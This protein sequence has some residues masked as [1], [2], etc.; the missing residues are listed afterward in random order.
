MLI[1][2]LGADEVRSICNVSAYGGSDEELAPEDSIIGQERAIRSLRLGLD[3]ASSG[4]N[5][6]VAGARGTGR[7]TA[8][9]RFLKSVAEDK[10]EPQDYCYVNNFKSPYEPKA[11][12]LPAG[13][14]HAFAS[15][16]SKLVESA[17]KEIPE[18][19]ESEDYNA[20]K[21][22]VVSSFNQQREQML[23]ELNE[24]ARKKGF[25]IQATAA[26]LFIVP[27]KDNQPMREQDLMKLDEEERQQI[28]EQQQELQEE[29][30]AVQ[31]KIQRLQV[32]A[33]QAVD[34]LDREVALY[35]VGE[36]FTDLE[37]KY[38]DHPKVVEYLEALKEDLLDNIELFRTKPEEQQQQQ[39]QMPAPMGAGGQSSEELFRKYEVNVLVDNSETKGAPVWEE[40]NPTH[41]NLFG[42][43]EKE[44]R[45]GA[46]ATDFTLIRAGA[47]HRANGGFLIVPAEDLLRNLFAWEGLK[48]ILQNQEIVIEEASERLGFMA[49]RS[50]NPE[51]IPLQLKVVIVGA[52]EIYH[53]LHMYDPDFKEL[54]KV[55][56]EFDTEMDCI[57][58]NVQ[59]YGSFFQT[60]CRKEDLPVLDESA[61]NRMVEYGSRLAANQ[62][63]LSTRFAD[64]ADIVRE[65]AHY[66]VEEG[67]D[68]ITDEHI[69]K[70]IE[71]KRYRSNL[72][73]EKIQE[74]MQEGRI[75]IETREDVIGQVNG[76]SVLA[77]GDI[78]FG[79]PSRITATVGLGRKGLI[80]IEREAQL[81]GNI[82]SKGVMILS[83]YLTQRYGQKTPINLTARLVFEQTYGMVEGDSASSAE[84]YA[85]LSSLS[86]LAVKQGLA[87]TGSVNQKGELQA[88]GGV[89]EKIEGI[90]HVCKL[91]GFTGGQGV[92][93]PEANKD[94]L[95]LKEEVVEAIREGN[96]H[97][98]PCSTVDEGI[99]VLTGVEA[100]EEG[101]DEAYP[102]GTVNAL[103]EQ[104]LRDMSEQLRDFAREGTQENES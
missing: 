67:G 5:I 100:G 35:V 38:A 14:G 80:D 98:Y 47:L 57:N 82:H 99:E 90:Y 85:L 94:D 92:V 104:R 77:L 24:R 83:G 52:P 18:A 103:V 2:S 10:P 78:A 62:N 71:E 86:G 61:V 29:L 87:V 13:K 23:E 72:L 28:R 73:E 42:R 36:L 22:D 3:I 44:A 76:L 16:V 59:K 30:K 45:M 19:F 69:R 9:R 31:R 56:A 50:L 17:R 11:L 51:P 40:L 49:T 12:S 15:D 34:E 27:V 41:N 68:K 7:T 64:L 97:V 74:H 48:R 39:A 91:Q 4:F 102:E 1:R 60:L 63:K 21:E 53:L 88:I 54:F 89:N 84:L 79:R 93:I 33:R 55:K 81:G 32:D 43:I 70:T 101:A 66:V 37:E 75:L 46:L 20:K 58:E 8:V 65:A 25:L 96:F 26:G 6:F 95:M